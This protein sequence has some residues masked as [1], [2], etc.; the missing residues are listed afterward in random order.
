MLK[1]EDRLGMCSSLCS[2][3]IQWEVIVEIFYIKL[4]YQ[5]SPSAMKTDVC[6]LVNMFT[7]EHVWCDFMM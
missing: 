7:I 4:S 5:Q 2:S 1:F 3:E 6:V